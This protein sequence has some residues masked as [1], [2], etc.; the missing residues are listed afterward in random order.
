[1]YQCYECEPRL[2]WTVAPHAPYTV[3]DETFGKVGALSER[4]QVPLHVHLHETEE[5]VRASAVGETSSNSCHLSK[6]KCRPLANL[7]RLGLLN[8]RLLAAHMCWL[9]D[10]EIS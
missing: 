8:E 7:K 9:T 10:E 6:E 2:S 3:S 4:L 5:E 1:M